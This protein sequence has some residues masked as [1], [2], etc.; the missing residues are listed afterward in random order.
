MRFFLPLL[1]AF[2]FLQAEIIEVSAAWNPGLC[3]AKCVQLLQNQFAKNPA[4]QEM[5]FNGSQ[6]VAVFRWKPG[7]PYSFAPINTAMRMVGPRMIWLRAKVSGKI[8]GTAPRFVLVSTGDNTRFS[9]VSPAQPTANQMTNQ[10]NID[11]RLISPEMATQLAEIQHANKIVT[12]SGPFFQPE[13]SPPNQLIV[14]EI[15]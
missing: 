4:I 5:Q 14:Q 6:G 10:Y 2:H 11:S 3:N 1:F 15:K 9:L 8:M 7:A 12:I 13:R